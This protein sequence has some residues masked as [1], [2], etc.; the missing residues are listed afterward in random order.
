MNTLSC[1]ANKNKVKMLTQNLFYSSIIGRLVEFDDDENN[2]STDTQLEKTGNSLYRRQPVVSPYCSFYQLKKS[3]L[4]DLEELLNSRRTIASCPES[5]TELTQ[6]LFVYGLKDVTANDIFDLS[7]ISDLKTDI[8]QTIDMFET[9]LSQV[10]VELSSNSSPVD[11][12]AIKEM[13][14]SNDIRFSINAMI[15][16]TPIKEPVVFDTRF[17]LIKGNYTITM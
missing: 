10:T 11:N 8:E 14:L 17:D 7:V 3:I 2:S 4:N 15:D 1:L 6:S 5:Y 9:R 12:N 13:A 16:V